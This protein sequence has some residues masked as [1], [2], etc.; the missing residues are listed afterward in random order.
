MV[1]VQI[2][3][4]F[5]YHPIFSNNYLIT[6]SLKSLDPIYIIIYYIWNGARLLEQ[7][8]HLKKARNLI[9]KAYIAYIFIFTNYLRYN[10][11]SNSLQMSYSLAWFYTVRY[12]LVWWCGW[13]RKPRLTLISGLMWHTLNLPASH[14]QLNQ[15]N[16]FR[17]F[18]FQFKPYSVWNPAQLIGPKNKS[19]PFGRFRIRIR[20]FLWRSN[21][22]YFILDGNSETGAHE[23]SNLCYL[24]WLR[25]LIWSRAVTNR[26]MVFERTY[27][28]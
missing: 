19:N 20:F 4:V 27:F 12:G 7:T 17:N 1:V 26:I 28:P 3:I 25:H 13:H 24:I 21:P 5:F 15:S 8:V 6:V 11:C 2:S 16:E 10:K 22:W 14:H 18:K 9:V 23:R